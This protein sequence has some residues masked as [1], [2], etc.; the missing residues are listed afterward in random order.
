MCIC[1]CGSC[2]GSHI[3]LR[4]TMPEITYQ[5]YST[6]AKMLL[7]MQAAAFLLHR[8]SNL[9]SGDQLGSIRFERLRLVKGN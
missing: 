3:L 2:G 5:G 9:S 6:G 8:T 7:R 1:G 4:N